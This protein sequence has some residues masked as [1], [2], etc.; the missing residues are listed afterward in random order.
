VGH[1]VAPSRGSLRQH[2]KA[3]DLSPASITRG[4]AAA[5]L[6]KVVVDYVPKH[7]H[8]ALQADM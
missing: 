4:F 3:A 5:M 6:R 7:E 8:E 2:R 1:P